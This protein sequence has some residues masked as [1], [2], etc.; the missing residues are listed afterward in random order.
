MKARKRRKQNGQAAGY[1]PGPRDEKILREKMDGLVRKYPGQYVVVSGGE[2]FVGKDGAA[3]DRKARK[4]HPN[5][6][7]L[8]CPIPKPEDLVCVL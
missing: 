1:N 2:I 7:P 3:L 6:T 5:V 8:G 4:K